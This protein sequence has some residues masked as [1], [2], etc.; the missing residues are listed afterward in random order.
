[1]YGGKFA[2]QNRWGRASLR[3]GRKVTVFALFYFVFLGHFQVQAGLIFGG[4]YFRNFTLYQ[5]KTLQA[6]VEESS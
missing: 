1:M 2:F 4:A 3:V 6:L 5:D